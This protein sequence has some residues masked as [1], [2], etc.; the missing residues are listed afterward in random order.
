MHTRSRAW[1]VLVGSIATGAAASLAACSD[2]A[3]SGPTP[4][5]DAGSADSDLLLPD[6]QVGNADSAVADAGASDAKADTATKDAAAIDAGPASSRQVERPLG[7]TAAGNGYFEYL[8]PGY[9]SASPTPLIVF[10]HGL[11]EVGN[12]TTDLRKVLAGGPPKLINSNAWPNSR[13]FIVLSPQN[14]SG[15]PSVQTIN[16]FF[17]FAKTKYAVDPKRIYLTGLSCGAIGAWDYIEQYAGT[18]VAAALLISGKP[19]NPNGIGCSAVSNLAL[20]SVHGDADGIVAFGPD[21]Q[22][23]TKLQACPKPPRRDVVWTPIAGGG[24]DVWTSTYDLSA[25]RGDVYA[26]MLAN[27]KP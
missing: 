7:T 4:T 16:A 10:W 2:D 18:T 14:A 24:H 27:A 23:T 9:D 1:L 26:W 13:P 3:L 15:C 21:S 19:S 22:T 8:P 11:G 5:A 17:N 20:W 25:G 12:G 6:R